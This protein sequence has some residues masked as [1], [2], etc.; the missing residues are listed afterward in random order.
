[1]EIIEYGFKGEVLKRTVFA[2]N[3]IPSKVMEKTPML[4]TQEEMNRQRLREASGHNPKPL[5]QRKER[6]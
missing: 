3:E 2:Y 1:M 5:L 6:K 4:F